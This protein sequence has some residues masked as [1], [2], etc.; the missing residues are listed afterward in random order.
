[1]P[2]IIVLKTPA[3]TLAANGKIDKRYIRKVSHKLGSFIV[4]QAVDNMTMLI[5]TRQDSNIA[6]IKEIT[7]EQYQEM[8]EK[9]QQIDSSRIVRPP[10]N[11][12]FPGRKRR[13]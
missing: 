1:M 9:R 10:A 7:E 5:S 4:E 6:Y 2:I 12:S 3:V 11:L 13:H 8:K